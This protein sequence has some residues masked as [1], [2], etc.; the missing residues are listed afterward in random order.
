MLWQTAVC[1]EMGKMGGSSILVSCIFHITCGW[2]VIA[3]VLLNHCNT[4]FVDAFGFQ[5]EL[6]HVDTQ[7]IFM[8]TNACIATILPYI[9]QN[10]VVC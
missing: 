6:L 5:L 10:S 4:G 8:L 1:Q 9:S 3:G 7:W 2:S